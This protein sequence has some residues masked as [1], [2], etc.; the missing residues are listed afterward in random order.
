MGSRTRVLVGSDILIKQLVTDF[1]LSYRSPAGFAYMSDKNWRMLNTKVNGCLI[2]KSSV[3][4]ASRRIRGTGVARTS[5]SA[6]S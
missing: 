2:S 4:A 6:G 5:Q 3:I 1:R